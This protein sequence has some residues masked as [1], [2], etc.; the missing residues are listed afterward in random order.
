MTAN[1]DLECRISNIGQVPSCFLEY[2]EQNS[3]ALIL[4]AL[5]QQLACMPIHFP[6]AAVKVVS[7]N[8]A[9]FRK[10]LYL[11]AE[12]KMFLPHSANSSWQ[13]LSKFIFA[14]VLNNFKTGGNEP[15]FMFSLYEIYLVSVR[16]IYFIPS[17]KIW[18]VPP[19]I[20]PMLSCL[21]I[22]RPASLKGG[23][24]SY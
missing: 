8:P 14:D 2:C 15:P 24:K 5:V 9:V 19:G 23:P 12:L 21:L 7:S 11:L 18:F 1:I 3:F 16:F 13:K 4:A 22:Q 17:L 20:A 10:S 6:F